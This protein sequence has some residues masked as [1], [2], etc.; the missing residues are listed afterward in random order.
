MKLFCL[1]AG[2]RGSAFHVD[3]NDDDTISDLKYAI[4]KENTDVINCDARELQLYLAKRNG[5]WLSDASEEMEALERG[6]VTTIQDL[7]MTKLRPVKRLSRVFTGLSDEDE[8]IHVLV[9]V[10]RPYIPKDDVLYYGAQGSLETKGTPREC[11]D[12]K[13]KRTL[14]RSNLTGKVIDLLD[15][16]HILLIKSPPMTGKSSL[17]ALV[18]RKLEVS[19]KEKNIKA[20]IASFSLLGNG[21]DKTFK[22]V[23]ALECKVE[24]DIVLSHVIHDYTV[25]VLVDE[26]QILYKDPTTSPRRKSACFWELVKKIQVNKMLG[27]RILMFAAYGSD[28]QYTNFSTP[29]EIPSDLTLGIEDLN[30]SPDEI[31][32]Y[33]GNWF[34]GA[35]CLLDQRDT[36]CNRL[37]L[38]TGRHVGLCAATIS[39]LN[40]VFVS[41]SR[42]GI[43]QPSARQ[44]IEMVECG[45]FKSG[46]KLDMTTES[47]LF[48]QLTLTR[49]VRVL[50]TLTVEELG[51]LERFL[52]G[53]PLGSDSV[54][55][56]LYIRKGILVSI[57]KQ[58]KFSSPVMWRYFIKLRT[59]HIERS[60]D[61]PTTLREL[62]MR[63]LR[64]INYTSI[65][66]T[67]G[68]TKKDDILLE[69]VWQMEFY[70]AAYCSTSI[71]Y[72]TSVDVGGLFGSSGCI[73]F[74]IGY[75]D[76]LWGVELVREGRR[77]DEH[78]R[79]FAP[80]GTYFLLRLSDY[81]LIDFRR[82]SSFD[83]TTEATIIADV[84][85]CDK[86]FVVLYDANFT[87]VKVFNIHGNWMVY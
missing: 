5:V 15:R 61:G 14:L 62:I 74:T 39:E 49:S 59:G 38:L 16:K 75:E 86:L 56:D 17:A 22:D 27:I 79:R 7:L 72:V 33:V 64:S 48:Q 8:V 34:D 60:K 73:D 19:C 70:K 53:A 41:H 10:P 69:R 67:L 31:Q 12:V 20:V 3:I 28:L 2:E 40:K 23:F 63:V 30:F 24:W 35:D 54:N 82:V 66:E 45:Y 55:L 65:Y 11:V 4:K 6:D 85:R 71:S 44:W 50:N 81:C 25:Y 1:L 42:K 21:T 80:H 52:Y 46:N 83:D 43:P 18:S 13:D 87:H 32:E 26:A 58:I 78:I 77:L 76:V 29:V 57:E 68:K 51:Y 36:F 37:A 47:E 84:E 9:V